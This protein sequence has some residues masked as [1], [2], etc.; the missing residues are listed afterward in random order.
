MLF[1]VAVHDEG[2]GFSEATLMLR[3]NMLLHAAIV[4][5]SQKIDILV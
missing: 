1:L 5:K 3:N 2:R 4:L